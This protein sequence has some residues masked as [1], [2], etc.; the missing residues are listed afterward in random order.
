MDSKM[1]EPF[2]YFYDSINRNAIVVKPQKP[3]FDWIN[4]IYPESPVYDK[5]EAN[6]YLIREMES[7]EAI[8]KWLK[9]N[10]DRIFQNELNDWHTAEED[11]PKRRTFKIFQEW[12]S[13]EIHSMVLD[14]EETDVS[15]DV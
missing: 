11:C 8:E 7:N 13:Y 3:F 10:F 15:K 1:I 6:I 14:L 4:F 5:E 2:P 9:R 12:F